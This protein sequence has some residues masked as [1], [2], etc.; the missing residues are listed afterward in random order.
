MCQKTTLRDLVPMLLP[1]CSL[2]WP[3]WWGSHLYVL[4]SLPGI[5]CVYVYEQPELPWGGSVSDSLPSAPRPVLCIYWGLKPTCWRTCMFSGGSYQASH[6]I[7]N[8]SSSS[9]LLWPWHFQYANFHL[10]KMRRLYK[11]VV[12]ETSHFKT[13]WFYKYDA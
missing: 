4:Q 9:G 12:E 2:P 7:L 5:V 13:L 1:P 10:C 11:M 6:P 8:S 3:P